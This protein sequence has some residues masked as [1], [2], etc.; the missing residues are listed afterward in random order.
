MVS[1]YFDPTTQ[2]LINGR[3]NSSGNPL[4]FNNDVVGMIIKVVPTDGTNTG[5]GAYVDFYIPDGV[6]V[7]D[8]AYVQPDGSGGYSEVPMKGQA[9]MPDVGAG[10]ARRSVW[11][12]LAGGRIFWARP[13]TW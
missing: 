1:M 9:L 13:R 4:L 11:S 12:A 7:V 8:A 2:A 10:A 6:T 3:V 5:V